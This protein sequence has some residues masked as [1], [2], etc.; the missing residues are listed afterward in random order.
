MCLQT[1]VVFESKA[2]T[3]EGNRKVEALLV[4]LP[5]QWLFAAT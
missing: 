4:G 3:D 5:G 1:H 2:V